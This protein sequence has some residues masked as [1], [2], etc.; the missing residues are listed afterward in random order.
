MKKRANIY[1]LDAFFVIRTLGKKPS[2]KKRIKEKKI[3]VE[4]AR[5]Q[6]IDHASQQAAHLRIGHPAINHELH[7]FQL[8]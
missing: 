3:A 1:R 4:H 7:L 8:L 5:R 2:Q 6:R